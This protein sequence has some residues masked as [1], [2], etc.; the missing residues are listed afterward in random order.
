MLLG[1]PLLES[2]SGDLQELPGPHLN[3]KPHLDRPHLKHLGPN[4]PQLDHHPQQQQQQQQQ[5]MLT[6]KTYDREL[7]KQ[8]PNIDILEGGLSSCSFPFPPTSPSTRPCTG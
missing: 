6:N 1:H 2:L 5:R 4:R 7:E 8:T 3:P